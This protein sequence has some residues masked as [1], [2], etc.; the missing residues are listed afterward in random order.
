MYGDMLSNVG[1][2]EKVFC[3]LDRQPNLPPPGTLAPPTLQ[4]RVEFQDVSF[5][6]PSRPDQPVLKGLT[7]TLHPG[8]MTALVGPNG[9]GKTTVAALLQNLYQPT[10]GKLLLDGEPISKYEHG[11]LHRQVAVVGQ[12]PVLFSGSVRD[13]IT[14]GLKS[15]SDEKVMAA[16]QAAKADEFIKEMEHGLYTDVGEK[17]NQLAVGQKQ[18]LAIA[19][20]LVRDPRVLILDEATSALDVQCEQALQDWQSRGDRTVL[21]IAHRLQTIQSADQI[22][23]LRQGELLEH[24]QLMAG[25]DLYSRLVQQQQQLQD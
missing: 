21:V 11:Y 2:A 3:Y 13:N 23:V 16:A 22:L 8:Q 20:A 12:E 10:G 1:A 6:Y 7:F 17:G 15:C 19:R 14:Y 18:R 9:S 4:G 5:A 25:Q 24:D